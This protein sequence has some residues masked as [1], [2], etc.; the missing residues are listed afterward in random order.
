M[1][2][3]LVLALVFLIEALMILECPMAL[4][5]YKNSIYINEYLVIDM[6]NI[7]SLPERFRKSSDKIDDSIKVNLDGLKNLNASG[8]AQFAKEP[9]NL[10][11]KNIGI[12]KKITVVDLRQESHGFVNDIAISWKGVKNNLNK[13]L[14]HCQVFKVENELLS[15]INL[16]EPLNFKDGKIINPISVENE[17]CIVTAIGLGYKRIMVTDAEEATNEEIDNFVHFVKTLPKDVWLHFHCDHGKGRTTTFLAMYDMMRNAKRVS[18]ED[19]ILR[20]KLLGGIDLSEG[21]QSR[22]KL[23]KEFYKYC[24]ENSD[25][26]STC[27]NAWINSQCE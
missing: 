21:S 26:F 4:E 22:Y 25:E 10:I 12:N 8:S 19:I 5:N 2:K 11:K 15:S 17:N 1:K 18:F 13:G 24:K 20:Q 9:L 3:I 27:W 7:K 6:E 23:I 16:N 14:T